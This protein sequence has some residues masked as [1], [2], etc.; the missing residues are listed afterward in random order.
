[1]EDN[2]AHLAVNLNLEN[3]N[4]INKIKSDKINILL[5]NV[6]LEVPRL[7]FN[8]YSIYGF[9]NIKKFLEELE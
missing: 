8:N 1:M 7:E 9:D 5:S 6:E 4:K 3:I 2:F